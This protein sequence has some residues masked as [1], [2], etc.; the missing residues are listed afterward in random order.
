MVMPES[1]RRKLGM[2]AGT[3]EK[4]LQTMLEVAKENEEIRGKITEIILSSMDKEEFKKNLI[5]EALNDK[6][7]REKIMVEIIKKL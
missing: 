3:D 7:L 5:R 4:A 2:N 6:E 1:E